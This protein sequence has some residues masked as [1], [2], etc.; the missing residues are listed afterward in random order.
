LKAYN[1][2]NNYGGIIAGGG[3]GGSGGYPKLF[4]NILM[5]DKD[6]N[7]IEAAW[8]QIDAG[9]Q[10]G[11]TPKAAHDYMSKEVTIRE[12]GYAY[13]FVSNENPTMVDFYVDDIEITHTPSNVIQY[14]EYYP[15]G[16]QTST[17]W[18]RESTKDNQY[19]YNAG[20][21]LNKANGWYEMYYR[22]Y[23]P[24]IG[25][26][27]QVD[28]YAPMY[29]SSTTYNYALNNPVLINDPSGGQAYGG[30]NE[31]WRHPS[32]GSERTGSGSGNNW[33]E[34]IGGEG[35]SLDDASSAGGYFGWV[36]YKHTYTDRDGE[37]TTWYTYDREWIQD[38]DCEQ[39][40]SKIE[41]LYL[42]DYTERWMQTVTFPS[43]PG[44]YN[45]IK[46]Q[47]VVILNYDK[48]GN[49]INSM[50]VG[51]RTTTTRVGGKEIHKIEPDATP[52]FPEL[53]EIISESVSFHKGE[54]TAEIVLR[55]YLQFILAPTDENML[56][57]PINQRKNR[58]IIGTG[59]EQG[60]KGD[61]PPSNTHR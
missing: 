60:Y 35:W 10:V 38:P 26:M 57:V 23:D 48:K 45:P 39:C 29:A 2:L 17:S 21:E 11:A 51:R 43:A 42:D 4:V 19:L 25:R 53:N 58:L 36:E 46:I 40:K 52:T 37:V 28:P 50:S 54:S 31:S 24:A 16:L 3:S 56:G 1:T 27:L 44:Q 9:E 49:L 12:E 18:T 41:L 59:K 22:G 47:H 13:V 61:R 6:F 32:W 7:F 14:N 20:S 8:E 34:G 5:F 55:K 30:M 33:T 15:F